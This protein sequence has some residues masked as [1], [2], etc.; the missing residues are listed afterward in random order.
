MN[1]MLYLLCPQTPFFDILV[2]TVDTVRFGFLLEKL[3][4]VGHSVL[5]T[6]TT[7]VGKVFTAYNT[8][9]DITITMATCSLSS[10]CGGKG[11]VEYSSRE[12]QCGQC[13]CELL[14]TNQQY[15]NPGAH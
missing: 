12:E 14:C 3:L 1:I 7:G 10:V 8:I 4:D 6:G 5:F 9:M 13:E 15:P 2:P 11:D